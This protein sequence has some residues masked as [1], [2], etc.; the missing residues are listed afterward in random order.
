M[1]HENTRFHPG[2]FHLYDEKKLKALL[3]RTMRGVHAFG[4]SDGVLGFS[5][6]QV[7]T[8]MSE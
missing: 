4:A 6:G 3:V 7:D 1:N 5:I 2:V 8:P